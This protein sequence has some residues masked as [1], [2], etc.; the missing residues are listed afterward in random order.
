MVV[1]WFA[2]D[3]D[4]GGGGG[5]GGGGGTM[6]RFPRF[7]PV[8]ECEARLPRLPASCMET[9]IIDGGSAVAGGTREEEDTEEE[10]EKGRKGGA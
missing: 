5:G 7:I 9:D 3:G 6:L 8:S 10:E 4:A 1:L 2:V